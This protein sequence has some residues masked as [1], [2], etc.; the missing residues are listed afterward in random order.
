M[1]V[2]APALARSATGWVWAPTLTEPTNS[3]Q[4]SNL[5][6]PMSTHVCPP[7][8]WS[9]VS[10]RRSTRMPTVGA[11]VVGAQV[12]GGGKRHG[13]SWRSATTVKRWTQPGPPNVVAR[14]GFVHGLRTAILRR[15]SV[16]VILGSRQRVGSSDRPPGTRAPAQSLCMEGCPE[17]E[18]DV[19]ARHGFV[20]GLRTAILCHSI[21]SVILERPE[22][23]EISNSAQ[24]RQKGKSPLV[25]FTFSKPIGRCGYRGRCVV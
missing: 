11:R 17:L 10:G 6:C 19:V 14:H 3:C 2:C 16:F 13:G 5:C 24:I 22:I 21:N 15:S 8:L 23:T 18:R 4:S 25:T 7:L 1:W 9:L 20:H 12:V